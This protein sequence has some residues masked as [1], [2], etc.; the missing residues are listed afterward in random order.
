[1]KRAIGRLIDAYENGLLSKE[2]FERAFS[3]ARSALPSEEETAS[4]AAIQEQQSHLRWQSTNSTISSQI[5][6]G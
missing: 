4:L 6:T 1:V 3:H 2:E 5:A